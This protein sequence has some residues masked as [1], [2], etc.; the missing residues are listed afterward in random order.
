MNTKAAE[1]GDRVWVD[2][3]FLDSRQGTL[4]EKVLLEDKYRIQLLDDRM[5]EAVP[6]G[7][8]RFRPVIPKK[9]SIPSKPSFHSD[10]EVIDMII[11][12]FCLMIWVVIM[13]WTIVAGFFRITSRTISQRTID[14]LLVLY[15]MMAAVIIMII[16]SAT[17]TNQW[18]TLGGGMRFWLITKFIIWIGGL[19][20]VVYL[21]VRKI[22]P[23]D[24]KEILDSEM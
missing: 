1:Q 15:G 22:Y 14:R 18:N 17:Q 13:T 2:F 7:D 16:N 8:G 4:I 10:N 11:G 19:A 6:S 20:V 3:S 21:F 5:I 12:V 23:F 9:P 24:I